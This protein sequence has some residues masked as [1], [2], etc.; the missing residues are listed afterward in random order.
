MKYKLNSY[1]F[2]MIIALNDHIKTLK[3]LDDIFSYLSYYLNKDFGI[4]KFE[5]SINHR[6][7]YSNVTEIEN[8]KAESLFIKLNEND[9]LEVTFYYDSSLEQEKIESSVE[10]IKTTFNLISQ[11]IYNKY[12]TY[13]IKEFSLK[14]SLTGLYNRQYIDEYLKTILPLSNREKKKIAFLKIGID[15]F[16]AVIDEF[17]YNIG[18]KVLQELAVSLKNSVRSSDVVARIDSDEFLVVLHN[19]DSEENTIKVAQKIIENFKKKKVIVN[20]ITN[21]TLMKTICAGISMFPDDA[22]KIEEIFRSSDIAL[23]E[24]K[25]RGRSQFFKFKKEETN[26]IELF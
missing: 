25:N 3:K 21:Q 15:H 19:V 10:A 16:K 14:D 8:N 6:K 2:Q 1:N 22:S 13:Q 17:D 24:A 23:Y 5:A 9:K 12:L 7:I 11:T 4:N 20:N 26:T 18:D